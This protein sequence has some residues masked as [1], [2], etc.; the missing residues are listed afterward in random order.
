MASK[1]TRGL[2]NRTD[3]WG[4]RESRAFGI[5]TV[6]RSGLEWVGRARHDIA[7]APPE[8]GT[9]SC[10]VLRAPRGGDRTTIITDRERGVQYAERPDRQF[11]RWLRRETKPAREAAAIDDHKDEQ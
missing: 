6:S 10:R 5:M 11:P 2:G 8:S 3:G 4:R 1:G 7:R 9:L